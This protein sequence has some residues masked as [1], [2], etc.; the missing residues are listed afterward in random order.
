MRALPRAYS[1]DLWRFSY[2]SPARHGLGAP[3]ASSHGQDDEAQSFMTVY[4][5][6][7]HA[8]AMDQPI[9]CAVLRFDTR[10]LSY[11]T[12]SANPVINHDYPPRT[13]PQQILEWLEID[14][15]TGFT[16]TARPQVALA[17]LNRNDGYY[18]SFQ[19]LAAAMES[20]EA[21]HASSEEPSRP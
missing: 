19:S 6:G 15:P 1:N 9:S 21:A 7:H 8:G 11:T 3:S 10:N 4:V 20:E 17:V 16:K 13:R 14:F 2:C 18:P 12:R 5:M